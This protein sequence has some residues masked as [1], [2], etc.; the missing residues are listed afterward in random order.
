MKKE[1][2]EYLK[3]LNEAFGDFKFFPED[4]HY[5]Y[6]GKPVGVSVTKFYTQYEQDFDAEGCAERVGKKEGK[7]TQEVLD[8]WKYKNEFATTK[9]SSVHVFV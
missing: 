7:N 4:H 9:G 8:E 5:E 1:K 6:R 3:T 2:E